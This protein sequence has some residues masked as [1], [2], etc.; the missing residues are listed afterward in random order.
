M[1]SKRSDLSLQEERSRDRQIQIVVDGR[2]IE[3]REGVSIAAALLAAGIHTL[4]LSR[5]TK[6]PRGIF[7]GMGVCFDCLVTVNGVYNVRACLTPVAEGMHVETCR[8][9]EL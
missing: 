9:L 3:A 8:E 1:G 2:P 7:C 6:A 4:H 5:K